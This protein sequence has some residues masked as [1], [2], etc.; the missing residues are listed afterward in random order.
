MLLINPKSLTSVDQHRRRHVE[1]SS[2]NKTMR[3]QAPTAEARGRVDQ[4]P[5]PGGSVD[6]GSRV[7]GLRQAKRMTLQDVATRAGLS[8]ATV[9]KVENNR[10]S[11]TYENIIRLARGLDADIAALFSDQPLSPPR[12][13]RSITPRGKGKIFKTKTYD[14]EMLCTDVVGKKIIPLKAR[15]NSASGRISAR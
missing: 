11:P 10:L 7:R 12:G 9:S 15:I 1:A 6:L 3:P 2:M 14:Y 4:P 8:A 5:S 13:R